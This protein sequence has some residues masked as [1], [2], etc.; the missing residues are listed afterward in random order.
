MLRDA[1]PCAWGLI[2]PPSLGCLPTA[3]WHF[4]VMFPEKLQVLINLF[5]WE[6]EQKIFIPFPRLW[7]CRWERRLRGHPAPARAARGEGE[8]QLRDPGPGLAP[9][10][11]TGGAPCFPWPRL[12]GGEGRLQNSAG[13]EEAGGRSRSEPRGPSA[14]SSATA[15]DGPSPALPHGCRLPREREELLPSLPGTHG[16]GSGMMERLLGRA[17]QGKGKKTAHPHYP[18][19]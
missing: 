17:E 18:P 1:S 13:W 10:R 19:P 4:T 8:P 7:C 16:A 15:R 5:W 3:P 12:W 14:P 9:S 11:R 2:C 6:V